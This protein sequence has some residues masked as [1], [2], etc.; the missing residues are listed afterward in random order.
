MSWESQWAE[1][2]RALWDERVP[3]H[4]DGAFYDVDG[5]LAGESRL[6]EFVLAELGSVNG[7]T[8]V[9]PQ[10]HFGLDT[11][12]WA[13][14]GATVTGLDFSAP[15]IAAARELARRAGIDAEFVHAEVY[16]AVQ[17][18]GGRTFDVVYTGLGAM[19]WLPD[20]ERWAQT[21]AALTAPGGRFYFA[22]FH[23]ITEVFA[24]D[25]LELTKSYFMRGPRLYDEPGTYADPQ[26]QT[27]QTR[28]VEWEHTIGDV[29]SALA[30][31]GLRIEFLHEHD[32]TVS[33]R[34]P[35]LERQDD[36]SYRIPGDAVSLPLMYSLRARSARKIRSM[37][38]LRRRGRAALPGLLVVSAIALG[39][40][41]APPA[42]AAGC[43][44]WM[45]A[46][47]SPRARTHALLAAMSLADKVQMVTGTGEFNPSRQIRRRPARSQPTPRSAFPRWC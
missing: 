20:V 38:A 22:E 40:V 11:L 2:N 39:C 46:K 41:T 33:P 26:A 12:S 24:D 30:A 43:S 42:G 45:S 17:A 19:N 16:D 27:T 5:F 21:M 1:V 3:I 8:L 37:I 23:P 28:S 25:T 9:H 29:V 31:A 15:A 7:L 36:G 44:A 18:L 34:W 4:V 47:A 6:R 10:C 35:F 14:E 13:R 32:H